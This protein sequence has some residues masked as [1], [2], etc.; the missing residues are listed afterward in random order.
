VKTVREKSFTSSSK[1]GEIIK[2]QKYFDGKIEYH[3]RDDG[4]I[5]EMLEFGDE[6]TEPVSAQHR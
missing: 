2:D 1:F 3:F 4:K 6:N 5:I